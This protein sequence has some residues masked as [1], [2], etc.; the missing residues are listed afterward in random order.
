M[1]GI[2]RKVRKPSKYLF[3]AG[4]DNGLIP[5]Y[6]A[7]FTLDGTVLEL[8]REKEFYAMLRENKYR[9]FKPY[10]CSVAVTTEGEDMNAWQFRQD[11]G[12]KY[13]I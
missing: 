10:N 5:V 9:S 2:K 6:R 8:I 4:C 13:D 12:E 1:F 11:Y 7:Y 3:E